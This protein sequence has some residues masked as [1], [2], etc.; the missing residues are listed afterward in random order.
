MPPCAKMYKELKSAL[1]PVMLKGPARRRATPSERGK[2]SRWRV[3]RIASEALVWMFEQCRMRRNPAKSRS[4]LSVS[5]LK[6]PSAWEIVYSIAMALACLGSYAVMKE[7]LNGVVEERAH[8][9]GGMWA[10]VSTAFVFRDSRQHSL[11]AGVGRLIA[12]FVSFAL[13]L[14]YLWFIPPNVAGM[15]IL[16][17]VGT[18]LMMQLDRREDIITTAVTTIVIMV[19]ALQSPEDAWKQPLLRLF[20]TLVG[21]AI[22]MAGKWIASFAFYKA[23]GEPIQ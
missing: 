6:K 12:T 14:P 22:G 4:A 7:L 19:V 15:A 1:S 11:S 3:A 21:V 16:L 8:L 5:I 17:A 18:L 9:V 23:R 13:C 20:D 2:N 10:A